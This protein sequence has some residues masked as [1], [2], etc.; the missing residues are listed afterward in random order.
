M[1]SIE[2]FRDLQQLLAK[3]QR[4]AAKEKKA[5]AHRAQ[6]LQ[7]AVKSDC[8]EHREA[9]CQEVL[10]YF[11]GS[12]ARM[13]PE[14]GVLPN[15]AMQYSIK[16]YLGSNKLSAKILGNSLPEIDGFAPSTFFW[17]DVTLHHVRSGN[18]EPYFLCTPDNPTEKTS[19]ELKKQ[20]EQDI[21]SSAA[22]KYILNL[23]RRL[24]GW[25]G[26]GTRSVYLDCPFAKN[27]WQ[28]KLAT[29]TC[30]LVADCSTKGRQQEVDEVLEVL[31]R[32]TF[33]K[34]LTREMCNTLTILGDRNIRS[35]MLHCLANDYDSRREHLLEP[36]YREL[37]KRIG[38]MSAWRALG[39]LPV[40]QISCIIEE[41]IL[42]SILSEN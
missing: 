38:M 8:Q 3:E 26:N 22:E 39:C 9:F 18:I 10:N 4:S 19:N 24:S 11:N 14:A 1:P 23:L 6:L 31:Q 27:W 13:M 33:W 7:A 21:G 20:I 16:D 2:E 35:G 32:A 30:Q 37:F 12:H 5:K 17:M 42:P 41:E 28:Y 40:H 36:Q 29:E 25:L 15:S 34:F